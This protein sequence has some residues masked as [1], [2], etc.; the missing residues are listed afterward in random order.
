MAESLARKLARCRARRQPVAAPSRL[1]QRHAGRPFLRCGLVGCRAYGATCS[2]GMLTRGRVGTPP[3]GSG[4]P[5]AGPSPNPALQRD[6][7]R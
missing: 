1:A 2:A 7:A 5:F 3:A 4:C 6:A